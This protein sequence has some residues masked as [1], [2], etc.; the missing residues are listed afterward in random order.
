MKFTNMKWSIALT[1]LAAMAMPLGV[2]AQNNAS[3][4]NKKKHH[5]YKVVDLGTLGGP[6]SVVSGLDHALPGQ[7]TVVG[8]ADTTDPNPNPGCLNPIFIP[9]C[10]VQHAFRWQNGVL[11]DLGALPGGSN[12]FPFGINETGW[13]IGASE[14]GVID[15][16]LGI[17]EIVAVLWR[18]GQIKNLGTL[19]GNE[20]LATDLNDRGR[21]VGF[22]SNSVTDPVSMFGFGTQTRPFIW[23]HGVM[24]DLGTL[25]GPDGVAFLMNERGQAIGQYF[26]NSTPNATTG[27][28]TQ[29]PILWEPGGTAVDLG[30]LGGTVGTTFWIN[31]RG[32]VVGQSN[33]AGDATFHSFLW[34]R[35][36]LTD[37]GT[38]GGNNSTAFALN[39]AGEVAGR[40]DVP[41]SKT[42]DAFLWKHGVMTDLGT[43]GGD[44]CSTANSINS[45]GQI[46]G[47]AGV[48][49]VGGRGWLWEN[50]GPIVDL[51]VLAIPGSGFHVGEAK[52][53]NDR[54][55][56]VCNGVLPNGD[57]HAI[58]LVPQG[59]CDGKCEDRIAESQ[60]Q[61]A[62][63]PV[64]A[65]TSSLKAAMRAR[66]ALRYRVP[67]SGSPNN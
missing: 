54:G 14:N 10:S 50:G 40:A 30:T 31:N 21:I 36:V 20:S 11:T 18:N 42:H 35:G 45:Q 47:D 39:D 66:F 43:P 28:P 58:L 3:Q 24:R 41:G 44:P 46:V 64:R 63:I 1:L 38:L 15:P 55:E 56:I 65:M 13:V 2:A 5:T 25:G 61:P 51:N 16:I 27:I 49:F 29:D 19:G 48:C 6:G 67:N 52:L 4:L 8:G 23:E 22:S 60:I 62:A 34:D 59:D 9:D 33:L 17:P 37:L 57:I 26:L 53:I 12:S 7:G 32:Q